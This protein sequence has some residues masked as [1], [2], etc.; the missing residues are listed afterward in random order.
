MP[1]D[2]YQPVVDHQQ[3]CTRS[4]I[5][6]WQVSAGCDVKMLSLRAV[7][8]DSD[9]ASSAK[10]QSWSAISAVAR[11]TALYTWT[12]PVLTRIARS[13]SQLH[14]NTKTSFAVA[15]PE[16]PH[17]SNRSGKNAPFWQPFCALSC[18]QNTTKYRMGSGFHANSILPACSDPWNLG[19]V[20][21]HTEIELNWCEID[22]FWPDLWC[23]EMWELEKYRKAVL[24]TGNCL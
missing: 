12:W 1:Q 18:P 20:R 13:N 3:L 19:A 22:C 10:L 2:L 17:A 15:C 7:E 23:L 11:E 5:H 14:R 16:F 4:R 8:L 21:F 6:L 24:C 9:H